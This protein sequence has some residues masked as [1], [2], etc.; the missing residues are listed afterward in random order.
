MREL[1]YYLRYLSQ[2]T[3][4][5]PPLTQDGIF[6]PATEAAVRAFQRLLDLP[7]DGIVGEQSWNAIYRAYLAAINAVSPDLRDNAAIPYPGVPL[8]TGVQS[9]EVRLLQIYLDRI[10][11]AYLEI[12]APA[13]TGIYGSQTQEAV[14]A[15]QAKFGIPVTGFVLA[16]TWDAIADLFDDLVQGSELREGQYPGFAPGEEE[17]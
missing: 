16:T 2:F 12:P 7:V 17:I 1:Q 3:D 8:V 9:E 4:E 15:F 10:A 6:G 13:V 14:E 11:E 5:I